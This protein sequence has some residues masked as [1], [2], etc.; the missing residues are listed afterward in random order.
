MLGKDL[1]KVESS[2][3]LTNEGLKSLVL[4]YAPLIGVDALY[5]FEFLQIKGSSSFEEL[6]KLLNSLLISIDK[7]EANLNKL[8]EYKLVQTL[9]AN[10]EDKYIF[11]LNAPLKPLE[12]IKNDIYVRDFI[13]K[14]SGEYYQS[15]LINIR[16][17]SSHK[18]YTDISKK[19]DPHILDNWNENHESFVKRKDIK[20]NFEFNTFFNVNEFLKDISTTLLPLKYRTKEI[21][22]EMANLADL[23]NISY[24]KMRTYIPKVLKSD[25]TEFDLKLLKYLCE[26]SIGEFKQIN[27][28]EYN[29]PCELFLMNKQ[30]GKE[31]TPSDKGVIYKLNNEYHLNAPVI[32]YLLE[33][34]LN[35]CDG[36]LIEKYL[37]AIASDL[38][39]NNVDNIDKAKDCLNVENNFNV[40]KRKGKEP[41]PDYTN[42]N[43]PKFDANKFNEI[44]KKR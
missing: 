21:L 15:L 43:N 19:L 26:N 11:V 7:L 39:R 36:K 38:H 24:E 30:N 29:V 14:T 44:M 16:E 42:A 28:G 22:K 5:L 8:N 34:A 1:F 6:T 3:E 13:L 2:H 27:P 4:F 31:L 35:Q 37:Y 17:F 32:N 41:K 40:T 12:F 25:S 20:E 10:N 18:E 9:K 33:Y 23:Y